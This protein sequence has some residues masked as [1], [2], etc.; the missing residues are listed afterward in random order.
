[1]FRKLLLTVGS[2]S[3]AGVGTAQAQ[4][5]INNYHLLHRP[6]KESHSVAIDQRSVQTA[7]YT[8]E[9]NANFVIPFAAWRPMHV[10][11]ATNN[12]LPIWA[13]T[14][15]RPGE[16]A[17]PNPYQDTF[18]LS[19]RDQHLTTD[20]GTILC[21]VYSNTVQGQVI[22]DGSFLLKL[23][24]VGG[25]QWFRQY[26][27]TETFNSV[28]EVPAAAGGVGGYIVCGA[29]DVQPG[30]ALEG[31]IVRTDAIGNVVW[32]RDVWAVKQGVQGDAEFNQVIPYA[33]VQNQPWFALT[34]YANGR[35]LVTSGQLV[36]TDVLAT[37]VDFNG[38]VVFTATYGQNQAQI[39]NGVV[40]TVEVGNSLVTMPNG[41]AQPDL[42]I[43]G[44]VTGVCLQ[45]CTGNAFED[46]LAMRL[47]PGG[48]VAFSSR[49]DIQG[50]ADEG[51]YVRTN[52][53]RATIMA[54]TIT[55][56]RAATGSLSEDVAMLR[57]DQ[58]GNQWTQTEIFGGTRSDVA[59]QFYLVNPARPL[60]AVML[61]TTNSYNMPFPVPYLI[62]RLPT[63]LKRCQ[64]NPAQHPRIDWPMPRLDSLWAQRDVPATFGELVAVT[65]DLG[66]QVICKKR[67][68]GDMNN[69]GVVSVSDIGPFVL[70]L[71]DP[72][73]Y[74][75]QFGDDADLEAGDINGDGT[76][77]VSDIGAFV[78]L[79]SAP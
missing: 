47:V 69:D 65:I 35:R 48:A 40:G 30:A 41:G 10:S 14:Y 24:A 79:L 19:P 53:T 68:V 21:G 13:R 77:S 38:N 23:D 1:M 55:S 7:N 25:V 4:I 39:P 33:T 29:D 36:D 20:G 26:P 50:Q 60:H 46:I 27:R 58:N 16:S 32:S 42:F 22:A 62:E 54:D 74:L 3:L 51:M 34:G 59:A 15:I 11:I 70:A 18:D 71:T 2:M 43:T 44:G 49:Y 64:D 28:I 12:L 17:T 78:D 45:G 8:T 73:A 52:A 63:I 5:Y 72:A 37:L 75:A 6:P 57:I 61:A 76:L 31:L 66:R 56:Y 9:L 67:L